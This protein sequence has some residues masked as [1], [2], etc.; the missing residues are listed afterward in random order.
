MMVKPALMT[1]AGGAAVPVTAGN[2]CRLVVPL[3]VTP[4]TGLVE[5]TRMVAAGAN[6][7]D[8]LVAAR[9]EN[10][11]LVFVLRI[12]EDRF[13][14]GGGGGGRSH[15]RHVRRKRHRVLV[16]VVDIAAVVVVVIN[17]FRG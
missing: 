16:T 4:V 3:V 7:T 2:S 14:V 8:G 15:R 13:E 9:N 11:R 10:L 12:F 5:L 17:R 6:L 1:A